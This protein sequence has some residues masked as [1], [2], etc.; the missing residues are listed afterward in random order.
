MGQA[1]ETDLYCKK[2]TRTATALQNEKLAYLG[3]GRRCTAGHARKGVEQLIFHHK[4]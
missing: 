4:W 1:V 3:F 2:G